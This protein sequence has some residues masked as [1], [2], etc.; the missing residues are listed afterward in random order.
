[1][2]GGADVRVVAGISLA[3]LTNVTVRI[4]GRGRSLLDG[5]EHS[6]VNGSGHRQQRSS[7]QICLGTMTAFGLFADAAAGDMACDPFA[8]KGTELVTC[9]D[10]GQVVAYVRSNL[11]HD[12]CANGR[13][14]SVFG[15]VQ[16]DRTLRPRY[17]QALSQFFAIEFV[18]DV[19][20]EH[21]PV[22]IG[23]PSRCFPD[24]GDEFGWPDG[25]SD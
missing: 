6:L 12:Q 9:N 8:D 24:Q 1:L 5:I 18:T 15:P 25:F 2:V 7:S 19:Q 14:Q 20:F 10:V 4:G 21:G 23:Q 16:D 13:F 17:S 22:N 11:G 3:W